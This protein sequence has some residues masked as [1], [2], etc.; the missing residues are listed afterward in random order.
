[1]SSSPRLQ[2]P[3]SIK[4]KDLEA[5]INSRISYNILPM[6]VLVDYFP[7]TDASVMTLDHHPVR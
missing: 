4:F 1:M 3:P 7:I 2:R 6:K 5:A